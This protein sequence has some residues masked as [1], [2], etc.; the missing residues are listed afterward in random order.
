MN[1]PTRH[2]EPGKHPDLPPPVTTV[3]AIGGLRQN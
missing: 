2:Y 1:E 3:G